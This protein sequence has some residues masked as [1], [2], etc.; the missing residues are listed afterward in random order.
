M[1]RRKTSTR[2]SAKAATS[3]LNSPQHQCL[4]NSDLLDE[5]LRQMWPPDLPSRAE[6]K[7]L[8]GSLR[9]VALTCKG[10]SLSAVRTLWRR[11]DNFLPLLRLL[12]SFE[13]R[14]DIYNLR[15]IVAD[16]EWAVFD[17]YAAYVREIVYVDA[18]RNRSVNSLVYVRLAMHK[19]PLLPN[20]SRFECSVTDP[21]GGEIILCVSPSIISVTLQSRETSSTETF[22]DMLQPD[23]P[24][25]AHLTIVNHP[26]QVLSV[27]GGFRTLKSLDLRR[28]SGDSPGVVAIGSIPLLRS[29]TTDMSGWNAQELESTSARSIFHGLTHLSINA[30]PARLRLYIPSFLPLIGST[31]LQ[32]I[33]IVNAHAGILDWDRDGGAPSAA[34]FAALARCIAASWPASL[35]HLELIEIPCAQDDFVAMEG[36]ASL[37]TL[38]I[39]ETLRGPLSEARVLAIIATWSELTT[40]SLEGVEPDLEF[41]KCV[42]QHCGALRTLRTGYFPGTAGLPAL[43]T[44]PVLAHPLKDLTFV[45]NMGHESRW[46]ESRLNESRWNALDLHLLARHLDRMFPQVETITGEGYGHRWAEVAKL[47][48]L[49]QDVRRTAWEQQ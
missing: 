46:N 9:A 26:S 33:A 12:P 20:L 10:F 2:S 34:T 49:C 27:C 7:R 16:A 40:L 43:A 48:S 19:L 5:I 32:S 17:R 11:L 24:H 31:Q 14:D 3:L 18:P 23:S 22:L 37:Q 38:R 13:L 45:N 8:R 29:F 6:L 4:R 25:L 28:L 36:I 42:A 15:G 35:K 47:V 44:T 30:A 41:F 1:S 39:H 21:P